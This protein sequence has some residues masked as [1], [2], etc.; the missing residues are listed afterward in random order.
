MDN[1]MVLVDP[2]G[3]CSRPAGIKP[4]QVGICIGIF[5]RK[6]IVGLS[7]VGFGFGDDRGPRG[8]DPLNRF[9]AQTQ[10]VVDPHRGVIV[11]KEA[12]A[13]LSW[14]TGPLFSSVNLVKRGTNTT[15]VSEPYIDADGNTRFTVSISA[16][17]G[18]HNVRGAPK[19]PIDMHITLVVTPDGRVGIVGGTRDGFP[20]LEIYRYDSEGNVVPILYIREKSEKDLAPPEEQEIKKKNPK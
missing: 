11:S 2:D 3:E 5:I 18:L 6:R 17:N 10:L 4:G 12:D 19:E 13:G 1:P 20:S 15:Q 8:N 16:L 7:P 14:G 9:R